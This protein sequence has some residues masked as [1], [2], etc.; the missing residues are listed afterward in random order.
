[1]IDKITMK[2]DRETGEI[3]SQ[4]LRTAEQ[5]EGWKKRCT[6]EAEI[7]AAHHFAQK[8][9]NE[10]GSFVWLL[11]NISEAFNLGITPANLTRIIYLATYM[12]YD[13]YLRHD[14]NTMI[15]ASEIGRMLKLGRTALTNFFDDTVEHGVLIK[16]EGTKFLKLNG[17]LFSRGSLKCIVT[18]KNAIRLYADG[19][20]RL[21]KKSDP[22]EHKTLA[23]VFQ[24]IPYVNLNYNI[25][26]SNPREQELQYISSLSMSKYCDLIGHDAINAPRLR[27]ILRNLTIGEE[28]VFG[29]VETTG[30]DYIIVNPR[31]FYAGNQYDRV[32][33]LGKFFKERGD[34][35]SR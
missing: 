22:K 4:T 27:S 32:M 33:V 8:Q 21:F 12:G 35:A 25:L 30:S 34:T 17:D 7:E 10:F 26:C 29:F 11:Y 18:D 16:E 20:R 23:Y 19:V 6:K 28:G 14:N 9:T 3:I 5:D 2:V 1:M 31:I 15:K 24:A 13:N